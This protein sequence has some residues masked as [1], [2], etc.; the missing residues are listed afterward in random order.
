MTPAQASAS[1]PQAADPAPPSRFG[2]AVLPE[3]GLKGLTVAAFVHHDSLWICASKDGGG[4]AIRAAFCPAGELALV[5]ASDGGSWTI[6]VATSVGPVRC[7]VSF[8]EAPRARLHLSS[9]LVPSRPVQLHGW[10]RDLV[11]YGPSRDPLS[12]SGVVHTKQRGLRT[13]VVYGSMTAPEEMTFLYLQ[14]E[15]GRPIQDAQPEASTPVATPDPGAPGAP[16]ADAPAS[17]APAPTPD[18]QPPPPPASAGGAESNPD[19]FK[20][21]Q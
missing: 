3:R 20:P 6:D 19:P 2:T 10:P 8:D 16:A 5:A 14:D 15:H 13:G 17:P 4:F 7:V 21:I 11:A 18:E 12:T 1:Q 9:R